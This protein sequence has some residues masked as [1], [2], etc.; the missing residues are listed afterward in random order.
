M[1]RFEEHNP[2]QSSNHGNNF[3]QEYQLCVLRDEGIYFMFLKGIIR[4]VFLTIVDI[5]EIVIYEAVTR[6]QNLRKNLS[7]WY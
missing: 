4:L 2:D 6:L 3:L 7:D 5:A 1:H